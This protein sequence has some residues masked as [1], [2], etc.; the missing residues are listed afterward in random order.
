MVLRGTYSISYVVFKVCAFIPF[1]AH[2]LLVYSALTCLFDETFC[3]V[4]DNG[5]K[6]DNFIASNVR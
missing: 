4:W 5:V 2:F 6:F 3:L 1:Y